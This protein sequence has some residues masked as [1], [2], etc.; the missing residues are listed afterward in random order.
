MKIVVADDSS[1]F[2]DRI[3]VIL[4]EIINVSVVGEAKNGTE[5]LQLIMH[6]KPDLMFLDIRMP[7][8]NGIEVFY[9]NKGVENRG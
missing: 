3:K 7:E 8:M 5:A 9:E 6:K 4:N 2:S 1:L